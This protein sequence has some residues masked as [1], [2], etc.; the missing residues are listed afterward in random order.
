MSLYPRKELTAAH[1]VVNG[2]IQVLDED[3][4]LPSLPEGRVTLRPHNPAWPVLDQ[5]I[6]EVFQSSLSVGGIEVVDIG[7]TERSTSDCITADTDTTYL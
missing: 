7:V 3:V 4:S 6:V 1:L 2:L 5:A